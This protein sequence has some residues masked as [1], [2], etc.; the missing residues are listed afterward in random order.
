MN[1]AFINKTSYSLPE[2][3]FCRTIHTSMKDLS[4][5]LCFRQLRPW[6][7]TT[8]T[9]STTRPVGCCSSP[10]SS[11]LNHVKATVVRTSSVSSSESPQQAK[12]SKDTVFCNLKK[13]L[14]NVMVKWDRLNIYCVQSQTPTN[15]M[16]GIRVNKY[17]NVLTFTSLV[18]PMLSVY[19]WS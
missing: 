9:I 8:V 17:V 15:Q 11:W 14:D 12:V 7:A 1:I 6:S 3:G 2:L 18:V 4:C 10:T 13:N 5:L 16:L 19:L